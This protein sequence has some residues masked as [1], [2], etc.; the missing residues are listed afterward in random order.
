MYDVLILEFKRIREGS[1]GDL[2]FFR[3]ILF[4]IVYN[5]GKI[6]G[7]KVKVCKFRFQ[8]TANKESRQRSLSF[9]DLVQGFSTSELKY[10]MLS[11]ALSLTQILFCLIQDITNAC[12]RNHIVTTNRKCLFFLHRYF[13]SFYVEN[14]SLVIYEILI[15]FKQIDNLVKPSNLI[16]YQN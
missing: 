15:A 14:I 4:P 8:F 7:T 16:F 13:M 10:L 3:N 9:F 5:V 11:E 1:N 2:Y 6:Q 12:S